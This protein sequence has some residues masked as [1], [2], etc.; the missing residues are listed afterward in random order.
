MRPGVV[1][2][3]RRLFTRSEDPIL[4]MA[5]RVVP[6]GEPLYQFAWILEYRSGRYV[7]QYQHAGDVVVQTA[8]GRLDRT[9]VRRIWVYDLERSAEEH[10]FWI[11]VPEDGAV[12]VHYTCYFDP[13]ERVT[14]RV[15]TFGWYTVSASYYWHCD[16]RVDPPRIWDSME[17]TPRW[18]RQ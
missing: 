10:L 9:G 13:I 12:D 2:A 16:A 11:D 6:H 15:S 5:A 3:V 17:R 8:F 7:Q 4:E 1:D 18:Q 14:E